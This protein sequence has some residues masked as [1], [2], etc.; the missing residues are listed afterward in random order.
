MNEEL[1]TR[2]IEIEDKFNLL[3]PYLESYS[4]YKGLINIQ[5]RFCFSPDFLVV[6][7]NPG[8]G[9]F[10]EMNWKKSDV[11]FP[12]RILIN[13]RHFENL[14][15]DWLKYGNARKNGEWFETEKKVKNR[16]PKQ[17]LE[18]LFSVYKQRTGR[19]PILEQN[20]TDFLKFA[21]NVV[22]TNICPIATNNETELKKIYKRLTKESE[23]NQIWNGSV[24][25][26]FK[27]RT[28]DLILLLKP[29]LLICVGFSVYKTL[30]SNKPNQD[31]KVFESHE[32]VKRRN[33]DFPVNVITFS[34]KG[35]WDVKKISD[36]VA[37]RLIDQKP[38]NL[39]S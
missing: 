2:I 22:Y 30:F 27:Q 4:E 23:L 29:K 17:F 18:I 5:S 12:N 15:L 36:L 33:A 20:R 38:F 14:D 28:I 32:V 19:N 39:E 26:F 7:I 11:K 10:D 6:G 35:A 16:F 8:Q 34:R 3:K 21:N 31:V 9:A 13:P 1:K 37:K 25:N 24:E